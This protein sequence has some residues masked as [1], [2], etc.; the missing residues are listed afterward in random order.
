MH[1]ALFTLSL[2]SAA[3]VEKVVVFPDRAQVTRKVE[4][5]C[6][7]RAVA[8]FVALPP[9][10]DP[11]TFRARVSV[12]TVEGLRSFETALE[13][14]FGPALKD[15]EEQLRKTELERAAIKDAQGR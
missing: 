11:Q 13:H 2:L 9:A 4:V 3:K 1:L 5:S 7:K 8:S 12:G 6:G 14:T 10:A 15:I